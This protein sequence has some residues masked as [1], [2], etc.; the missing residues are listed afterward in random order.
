MPDNDYT[1]LEPSNRFEAFLSGSDVEPSN[2]EEY[3]I[4]QAVNRLPFP[5][6]GS[7]GY[8][9]AVDQDE[10]GYELV[11]PSS[12]ADLPDLT[13]NAG[14]VLTVNSGATAVEWKAPNYLPTPVNADRGK[15]LG[16]KSGQ[17]AYEFKTMPQGPTQLTFSYSGTTVSGFPDQAA[18]NVF[19]D[20]I[21]GK[22]YIFELSESGTTHYIVSRNVEL[23]EVLNVK[24]VHVIFFTGVVN[25]AMK[26]YELLWSTD[27]STW[28]STGTLTA[29]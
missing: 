19:Q 27:E 1:G 28:E 20:I 8:V 13:G 4:Q 24:T 15:V 12:G 11:E 23:K 10:E 2:R 21:N 18:F 3:F 29:F 16:V 9:V 5:E 7:A 14:R 17:N 22:D 26:G 25:S 6:S